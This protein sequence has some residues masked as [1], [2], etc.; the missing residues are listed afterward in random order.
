[1]ADPIGLVYFELDQ[2]TDLYDRFDR[3][4]HPELHVG[5][6]T[7]EAAIAAGEAVFARALAEQQARIAAH[8]PMRSPDA[9]KRAWDN[10]KKS[11]CFTETRIVS[12]STRWEDMEGQLT[13]HVETRHRWREVEMRT[14]IAKDGTTTITHALGK[15]LP[16]SKWTH[17][18][19]G[20]YIPPVVRLVV[21]R[22][23][24]KLAA[25]RKTLAAWVQEPE[26]HRG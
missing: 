25:D 12:S 16:W 24:L 20:L 2:P 7:R 13:L 5:Y 3:G 21:R 22:R 1:M 18:E 26:V 15:A 11:A 6:T 14:S 17:G 9:V 23:E 19:G 10:E 8:K 4:V